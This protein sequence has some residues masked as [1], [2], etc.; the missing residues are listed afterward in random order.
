MVLEEVTA[1]L[2]DDLNK[3]CGARRR[4]EDS[5]TLDEESCYPIPSLPTPQVNQL[6]V[7]Q[8]HQD[9]HNARGQVK[10]LEGS[11]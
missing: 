2:R 11:L 7:R 3:K 1:S 6:V 9:L 10:E 5:V 4:L 8:L